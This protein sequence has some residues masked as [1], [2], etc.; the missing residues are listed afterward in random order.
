VILLKRQEAFFNRLAAFGPEEGYNK[1]MSGLVK[2]AS[3]QTKFFQDGD[4]RHYFIYIIVFFLSLVLF[5]MYQFNQFSQIYIS[6]DDLYFYEA[7]IAIIMLL[8]AF[9][10]VKSKSVLASVAALGIVGYGVALI[11]AFS[12]APDLALTQF[13]IETLSVI[14]TCVGGL[15]SSGFCQFVDP[16]S[17][18]Y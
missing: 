11:F 6:F 17:Q 3:A 2:L 14:L 5:S 12:S 15:Q 9:T 16:E 4:L 10:A 8:A 13:S 1:M 18:T 7:L